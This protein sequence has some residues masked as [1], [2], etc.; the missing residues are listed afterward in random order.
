MEVRQVNATQK[1]A[2]ERDAFERS[3]YGLP[4]REFASA[5]ERDEFAKGLVEREI[6][7]TKALRKFLDESESKPRP[8]PRA[9]QTVYFM[10][11]GRAVVRDADGKERE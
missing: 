1:M 5:R 7:R 6:A 9:D 3:S 10:D 8:E 11:D 4:P 2:L